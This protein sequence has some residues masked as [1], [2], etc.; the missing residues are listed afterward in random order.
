MRKKITC[1][2]WQSDR[3]FG[4]RGQIVL[5]ILL[6]MVV[7]L[8]VGLAAVARSITSVK[9]TT[10]EE[11]SQRAFYAAEA[12]LEA[13]L[14]A[15]GGAVPAGSFGSPTI[16]RYQVSVVEPYPTGVFSFPAVIKKDET[17]TIWLVEHDNAGNIKAPSG[18]D[19]RYP[20]TSSL[21][22]C[23]S[24]PG[25]GAVPALEMILFHQSTVGQNAYNVK[26]AAFDPADPPAEGARRN[27]NR[28]AD[29]TSDAGGQCGSFQYR[30]QVTFRG[31]GS[32]FNVPGGNQRLVA[33]RLRPIYNDARIAV[34]VPSQIPLPTLPPQRREI[35]SV[36]TSGEVTRKIKVFR[37]YPSTA[38]IFDFVLF[39]G[40]A[41]TK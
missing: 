22:V 36:G 14:L 6:I 35:E 5:I 17:K 19:G 34:Q 4:Q 27:N 7:G 8:T 9:I 31:G 26:R 11:Q 25:S 41:L 33:L 21:D 37:S 24:G 16:A 29:V 28:F 20:I 40:T 30:R 13:S 15:G 18:S 10:Q 39:S 12:G 3:N 32:T 1:D 23:W 38:P 2:V